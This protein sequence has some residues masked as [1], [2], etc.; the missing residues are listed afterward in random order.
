[1]RAFFCVAALCLHAGLAQAQ[2]EKIVFP[3]PEATAEVSAGFYDSAYLAK[4][5]VQHIGHDIPGPDGSK[6]LSPV[7]GIVILNKTDADDPM[8]AYLVI[9]SKV[10]GFEHVLGHIRSNLDV[11]T[12]VKP[13]TLVGYIVTA[14]SGPHLHYGINRLSVAG[15]INVPAGWG[16]GRGPATST[17]QTAAA[18]GWIDPGLS[19]RAATRAD[20]P[21]EKQ[22]WGPGLVSGVDAG[23]RPCGERA[24]TDA[25]LLE[26]GFSVEAVA[27]SFAMDGDYSGSTTGVSFVELGSVDLAV[28]EYIGADVYS[29]PMLINGP[30]GIVRVEP[31]VELVS[32]F[33]DEASQK[34]L[35]RY[36]QAF[37]DG[38][39]IRSHRLLPDGTQRFT[40]VETVM[41]GCRACEILGAAVTFLD[42]GPSTGGIVV[43]TPVGLLIGDPQADV[44]MSAAI[45]RERPESLQVSL[46]ALGYD[47]GMMDGYPG[48]KTRQALMEFQMDR[49]LTPTGQPDR[50]TAKILAAADGFGSVCA[51]SKLP[52]GIS[53]NTPLK[54]GVYVDDPGL[55]SRNEVPFETVHLQQRLINGPFTT[56][57]Y[58]GG[59]ETVRTDIRNGVTQF[60]GRC[61]AENQTFDSRWRFDLLSD[62]SFVDLDMLTAI[63]TDAR[64]RTFSRCPDQSPLARI[65][66]PAG[67]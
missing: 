10:T 13:G 41:D 26:L 27:F 8:A 25:C 60:R 47:A 36:P 19:V 44:E 21:A 29:L 1:M 34:M 5:K 64:P 35:R 32:V 14:G 2:E 40:L 20:A 33:G 31:S 28:A 37:A 3:V 52:D 65:W 43:R 53:A 66:A 16:F 4:Y 15:A 42:V 59:C 61:S 56:W 23:Y 45:F 12:E 6:V 18:L 62:E 58:E 48:P 22:E 67:N 9:R 54:S 30:A 55:C 46:N 39:E 7:D 51:G 24:A 63:P 17:I 50:D 38:M 11:S 49:C 57:G